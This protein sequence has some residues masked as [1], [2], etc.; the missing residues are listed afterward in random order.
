MLKTAAV[1]TAL[2]ALAP[3]I[4]D[5]KCAP[6]NQVPKVLAKDV[7]APIGGGVLV[8]TDQVPYSVED[9]G[10][11]LQPEWSFSNGSTRTKGATVQLAPGLVVYRGKGALTDGKETFARLTN[12][13]AKPTAL[14]TPKLVKVTHT[15]TR[16]R[17]PHAETVIEL[18][19]PPPQEVVAIVLAD[20][21]GK[22]R[23]YGLVEAGQP[24]TVYEHGRC[25]VLPNNTVESKLGDTVTVFFVD[26]YG[27]KS[28][29][30]NKVKVRGTVDKVGD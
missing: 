4:A 10:E 5:A 3:Q 16:G 26:K 27:F 8:A 22:P 28:A 20:A 15:A 21:A 12:T 24:L 13:A 25:G 17:R 6:M 9:R 14:P 1:L 7:T 19:A 11:A 2:L 30:S 23:S 18:A 29:V